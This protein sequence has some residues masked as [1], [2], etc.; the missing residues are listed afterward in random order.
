M[1]TLF[2][3]KNDLIL[4]YFDLRGEKKKRKKIKFETCKEIFVT[5]NPLARFFA[6]KIGVELRNCAKSKSKGV[7][8]GCLKSDVE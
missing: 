4:N 3:L 7:I 2:L 6:E 1:N 8:I 5:K